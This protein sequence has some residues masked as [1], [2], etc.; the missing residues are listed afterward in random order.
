MSGDAWHPG[1]FL[2]YFHLFH[3]GSFLSWWQYCLN[4][5]H[6][7]ACSHSVVC[8]CT[9]VSLAHVELEKG[10]GMSEIVVC[11]VGLGFGFFF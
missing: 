9:V 10:V 6:L 3:V 1:S 7:S 5:C 8:A 11:V 2:L 4:D